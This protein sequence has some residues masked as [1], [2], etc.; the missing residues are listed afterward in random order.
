MRR[1]PFGP[2]P[3]EDA[4]LHS[5]LAGGARRASGQAVEAP[6]RCAAHAQA[7]VLGE[8]AGTQDHGK[9]VSADPVAPQAPRVGVDPQV[10]AEGHSRPGQP[11][12]AEPGTEPSERTA[13]T[14]KSDPTARVPHRRVRDVRA[15]RRDHRAQGRAA[16]CGEQRRDRVGIGSRAARTG[17][18]PLRVGHADVSR[19]PHPCR[20]RDEWAE[21]HDGRT[22]EDAQIDDAFSDYD[23][24]YKGPLSRLGTGQSRLLG[25]SLARS[26]GLSFGTE[27]W[28]CSTSTGGPVS[29]LPD[30]D[31]DLGDPIV[32]FDVDVAERSMDFFLKGSLTVKARMD[33]RGRGVVHGEVAEDAGDPARINRVGDRVSK[34]RD[35]H[36]QRRGAR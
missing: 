34:Q 35:A 22:G 33:V 36:V 24:T 3:R 13:A 27:A 1:S 32:N 31:V 23:V 15:T 10:A 9:A 14:G 21:R 16:R 28:S 29:I 18:V 30:V 8:V 26:V 5:W 2:G 11:A 7:V 6:R 12:G 4:S 20:G 25:R 19:V 17:Q